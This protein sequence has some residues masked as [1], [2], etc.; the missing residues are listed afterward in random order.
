MGRTP[1]LRRLTAGLGPASSYVT[2]IDVLIAERVRPHW[3]AASRRID[4]RI[5]A[6]VGSVPEARMCAT[7]TSVRWS[8]WKRA[9]LWV[10]WVTLAF[11]IA[12]LL[13]GARAQGPVGLL[14]FV[15]L[16]VAGMGG[17]SQVPTVFAW[18]RRQVRARAALLIDDR[19]ALDCV[20]RRR[21]IRRRIR[22][23][24]LRRATGVVP[25]CLLVAA[26]GV[27]A[28]LM[29]L[30]ELKA[31]PAIVQAVAAALAALGT[32]L[33]LALLVW[34]R[35]SDLSGAPLILFGQVVVP[36]GSTE[37][38]VADGGDPELFGM[39][40][41]GELSSP[42]LAVRV[43]AAWHLVSDG[44]CNP[45]PKHLGKREVDLVSGAALS[46]PRKGPVIL[47]CSARGRCIGRLGQFDPA[48]Q[49]PEG[50]TRP[51]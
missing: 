22:R 8:N 14:F 5:A 43:S 10:P 27:V 9:I 26:L 38:E 46:V 44:S 45:S 42:V 4:A 32:L 15:T 30:E 34:R 18:R 17:A 13:T 3:C 20:T 48:A 41:I 12:L 50:H 25:A 31:A 37:A 21:D 49:H 6:S 19:S 35:C 1:G 51:R 47:V 33:T 2:H 16:L 39:D 24:L 40:S 36:V 23:R 11:L 28:G 29:T 7:M